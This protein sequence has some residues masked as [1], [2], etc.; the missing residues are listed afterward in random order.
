MRLRVLIASKQS[1]YELSGEV[2]WMKAIKA[3]FRESI[4]NQKLKLL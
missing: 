2:E 3:T 4:W 1:S